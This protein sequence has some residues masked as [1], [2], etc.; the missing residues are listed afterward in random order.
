[1]WGAL[2]D[3]RMGL[4]FAY[5]AGPCQRNLSRVRVPRDSRPYFTVSDLRLP[6]PSPPT[7]RSVTVEVAALVS[8]L[9][10]SDRLLEGFRLTC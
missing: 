9:L 10:Q 3:E 4:Y 2:S 1:M 6:F 7:A 8:Y 5:A